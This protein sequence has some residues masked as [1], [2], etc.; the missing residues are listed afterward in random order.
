MSV[1]LRV[2]IV[3]D[4]EDDALLVA[5]SLRRGG[6]DLTFE[7]VD[8]AVAMQAALDARDWDIVVTDYAMPHFSGL[9][10]LH[11]MKAHAPDIPVIIVSGTIGEEVAVAAMKA[12][13]SDY[14]MKDNLARLSPAVRRELE[15]ATVRRARRRAEEQLRKLSRAVE[16]SPVSVII[17]DHDGVIDY[18]NPR[19]CLLTGYPAEEIIG[20]RP[21]FLK[22]GETSAESYDELWQ[23][24]RA[25]KE[26]NGEFCNLKKDGT[27]YWVSA[28]ISPIYTA[29]GQITHYIAI[30]EDITERKRNEAESM[31]LVN[32]MQCQHT[33]LVQLA[34]HPAMAAGDIE[35]TL[36]AITTATADTLAV[37][38]VNIWCF[39]ENGEDIECLETF[40]RLAEHSTPHCIMNIL[41][42]PRYLAALQAGR[43]IAARDVSEDARTSELVADYWTEHGIHATIEAP[44]RVHGQVIGAVSHQHRG[45]P[46]DWYPDEIAFA[47]QIADLIAQ[48]F[49]N[50]DLR[51]RAD[52]LAAITRVN[53]EITSVPDSGPDLQQLFISIARHAAELSNADASGV[54]AFRDDGRLYVAAGYGVSADF[55]TAIEDEGIE[56]GQGGIGQAAAQQ[57]AVQ[58][59]NLY[60]ESDYPFDALAAMENI[61]AVLAVPMLQEDEVIGGIVLWHRAPR[62][63]STQAIAFIQA[64]TQQCVNA[65]ETARLFEAEARRRQEAETLRAVTQA[66]SA[67][68]DLQE[69]FDLIL[70]KLQQVVPYDSASVQQLKGQRMEIIG[71]RG[72]PDLDALL[73]YGFDLRSGNNP[74]RIVAETREP[75]ILDDAPTYYQDFHMAPHNALEVRA[76][77][78]VPLLFG[79]RLIGMLSLD[80]NK[81]G[82]YTEEHARLAMAFAAQAA[83]A[84]EN[85]RLF[86]QEE[87]R[88]T[89]LARALEQQRELDG[90]KDQ[91]IQNVSHEL[92]TP[93]AIARGYAEM[94]LEEA[95]G[96][97][98]QQ[99]V[100]PMSIIVRRLQMLSRLVDDINAIM[101]VQGKDQDPEREP[102]DMAALVR[103]VLDEFQASA[104][105]EGLKL[106]S[107]VADAVPIIS[108]N[109]VQLRRV[110]DNLLG[111]A[112]KFTPEGGHID[113]NLHH[114]N[115]TILLSVRDTG[116]GIASD[117]LHRI[118][119]RFYQVDGSMSRRYGGTGLGLAL[120]KDIVGAHQGEVHV[121]SEPGVGSTFTVPLPVKAAASQ[122]AQA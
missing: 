74:N 121:E 40:D 77:M 59:S 34:T 109:P 93:I 99:Q 5:M 70:A 81:Q 37:D 12:G 108:G 25:G 22:S 42:Y 39:A 17:T 13:A 57:R 68:L 46:R 114:I 19:F 117:Q 122:E 84:I 52:E 1:P 113:V 18:V 7:R 92:R 111:N 104:E 51:R 64:L 100:E 21:D 2:L 33:T 45:Q 54:F 90:L 27:A 10:A 11:L 47:S 50:A 58:I 110:L 53:R 91:F 56:L 78:G 119:D 94:L 23:T 105:Q 49:L 48:A 6:Y 16:Q 69:V 86:A 28:S 8:D 102:M 67:T 106:T 116:V 36:R 95:L 98:Q 15:E 75:L 35:A 118:F 79:D 101:D 96:E 97:L 38:R 72:F 26:W 3:D 115:G 88:A 20:R 83:I 107:F 55:L 29:S 62:H 41:G 66:L 65:V 14:V 87:D 44:V 61:H 71:G 30:E 63:F 80:R 60:A 24:I 82:F 4:S 120:V 85:A 103:D 32:R 43:V 76:W 31:A 73:H 112:L 9:Q 89:E